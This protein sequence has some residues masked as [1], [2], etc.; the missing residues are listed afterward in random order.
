MR[1]SRKTLPI[2][3]LF[4]WS[5]CGPQTES[6]PGR[7]PDAPVT[8]AAAL[9]G[10][11]EPAGGEAMVALQH[12]PSG[13]IEFKAALDLHQQPGAGQAQLRGGML[14]SSTEWPASLYVTFPTP[15]GTAACTAALIGPQVMLTAAHCVPV[16]GNVRFRYEREAE[17]YVTSCT[18]HPRY[19][20]DA[21][22]DFALCKVQ[23]PFNAPTGFLFETVD[24]SGMGAL[25]GSKLLL[26]GY[27][28]VSDIVANDTIDGKYR[29]GSNTV[30]ET[31]A[32]SERR[33]GARYYSGRE[34]NN[35][36]TAD[37]PQVANLCPGDSGGPAFRENPGGTSITS[38]SI[39]GVNSRVFYKDY[40]RSSYGS[41]LV[42]ATGGPDFGTWASS[43]T[44][45]EQLAACGLAGS[46]PNCRQ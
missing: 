27:G 15:D 14:A 40:T 4:A 42:S 2:A 20:Q 35:L 11:A 30:T 5:A 37:D 18:Q 31:S 26:T 8:P 39:I 44:A 16:S 34:E 13:D 21:S 28:C 46:V 41:S 25:V 10:A 36:F 32:S 29:I 7:E 19:A 12:R 24:T 33:R 17:P 23:R 1:L 22:A 6:P 38:R 9:A 3:L 45:S 43:W